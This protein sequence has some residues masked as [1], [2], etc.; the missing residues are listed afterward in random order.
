[1]AEKAATRKA[2][3]VQAISLPYLGVAEKFTQVTETKEEKKDEE[4]TTDKVE[5]LAREIYGLLR[6]RLEI[7]RERHGFYYNHR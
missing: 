6:Q 5:I 2:E 1:L 3:P 4:Q 7:E